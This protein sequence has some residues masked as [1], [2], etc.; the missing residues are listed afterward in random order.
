M[1][2][3]MNT[4]EADRILEVIEGAFRDYNYCNTCGEMMGIFEDG[5]DL[6]IECASLRSRSGFRLKLERTLHERHRIELP[7]DSVDI[8]A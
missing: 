5:D 2:T 4:S 7:L 3:V 1:T 6:W 8:A